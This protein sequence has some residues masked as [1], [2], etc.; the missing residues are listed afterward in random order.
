MKIRKKHYRYIFIILF[1]FCLFFTVNFAY[2]ADTLQLACWENGDCKLDDFTKLAVRAA[3]IMLGI[4]G[5]L[6]LLF[7]VYGGIMLLIS[8][9]SSER[10]T[11]GK[12]IIIGATLGLVI[13]F[14][15]W[16]IITFVITALGVEGGKDWYTP[17]WFT[18]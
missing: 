4:S 8:G 2:A 6:S 10:V 9:G 7:F 15:S 18:G 14:T 1:F 11:K 16:M 17:G 5:S 13:V 3:Q 12:Q